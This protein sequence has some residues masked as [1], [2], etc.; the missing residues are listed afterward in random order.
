M[1]APSCGPQKL[2]QTCGFHPHQ[3]TGHRSEGQIGWRVVEEDREAPR[4]SKELP[5]VCET[6]FT[7]TG[8]QDGQSRDHRREDPCKDHCHLHSGGMR[9]LLLWMAPRQDGKAD[10]RDFQGR[11]PL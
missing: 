11:P 10:E 5:W 1:Q 2:V 3:A 8:L 6:E 7:S 9:S 4:H